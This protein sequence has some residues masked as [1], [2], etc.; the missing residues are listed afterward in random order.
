MALGQKNL[1]PPMELLLL[2]AAVKVG[3]F[4][5]L[6]DGPLSEDALAAGLQADARSLWVVIEALV[7]TGY[8]QR[9]NGAV[10]L[11]GAAREMFYN[12][13][14]DCYTGFSFMHGYDLCRSWLSL[15]ETIRSGRPV[16]R[17]R[18]K[19]TMKN[20]ILS[21]ELHARKEAPVIVRDC[22]EGLPG[23]AAVLD[24]GGGPLTYA[25]EFASL[26]AKVTVLD[27]PEVVEMMKPALEGSAGIEMVPGDM[28]VALP[29]GPY[30]LAYL[31]NVCH[32]FDEGENRKIFARVHAVL[33]DG[34]MIAVQDFV[35]G[36]SPRAAMFGVNML[37]NTSGGGTWTLEQYREWLAG[38]GF[39]GVEMKNY[40]DRQLITAKK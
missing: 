2:G 27:L 9:V 15:P 29:R 38:A 20:F 11:T 35:R 23:G 31:G 24:I 12:P 21:M 16:K 10:N 26:G 13:Q 1:F 37:V 19:D 8:L 5:A 34:G 32:I 3:L 14:S 33:K 28:T 4:D 40:G 39:S 36:I 30:D 17:E 22:L 7:D 6:K 25:R 18:S